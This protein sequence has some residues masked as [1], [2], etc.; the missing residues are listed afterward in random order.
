LDNEH[1]SLTIEKGLSSEDDFSL[2]VPDINAL[3]TLFR[4]VLLANCEN[5]KE[6]VQIVFDELDTG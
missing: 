2:E 4:N 3:A 5:K 6:R 1:Q